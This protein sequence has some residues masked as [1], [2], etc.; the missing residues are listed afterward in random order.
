MILLSFVTLIIDPIHGHI[1]V[2]KEFLPIID[3]PYFQRLRG[4]K[5]NSL[6]YFVYP[7]ATHDRFAH[8]LGAYHLM[9]KVIKNGMMDMSK[10][11]AFHLK[12]A[13]LLHD[14]GHG[15]YSHLWER[16]V[17]DFDHEAMSEKI[18]TE[19]FNLPEVAKIIKKEH[20][21]SQ[22][23]SSVVDV[24]KLD[25]MSRD[26][27]FC[28]VGYG[29][30]D[31]SRILRYLY[32]KEGK[33][34]VPPKIVSSLEHV[35]T[36]RISLYK[37]TYYHHMVR[38]LDFNLIAIITR[39]RD[40]FEKGTEVFADAIMKK[41]LSGDI[42]PEDFLQTDDAFLQ[43]H[44]K[45]WSESED[46][47]LADLVDRFQRRKGFKALNKK[48]DSIP[49]LKDF[50]PRY[51]KHTDVVDKGVYE[52]EIYVESNNSFTPLSQASTHIAA[53]ANQRMHEE[54][55]IVP[56]ELIDSSKSVPK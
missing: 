47:I 36:G 28:G 40:L 20:P 48:Y 42:S 41:A 26:S 13:A 38:A 16:L 4:I 34:C 50:D 2:E 3:N 25:Y 33:L 22:L 49:D 37:S 51:Y 53:I 18:I 11:D 8:S 9:R 55:V 31:T 56:R 5:Q 29:R 27:Y 17:P 39:V 54:F 35:I 6:L 32:V 52:S 12:A 43:Y 15:P 7:S 19:V 44:L 14:I 21:Y 45:R 23:L 1:E 24:D 30:T 10:E 46:S